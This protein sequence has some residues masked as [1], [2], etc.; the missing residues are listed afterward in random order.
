M[1]ED[2]SDPTLLSRAP[3]TDNQESRSRKDFNKPV[4]G[5]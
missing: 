1:Y 5:G 4:K 3:R 2:E